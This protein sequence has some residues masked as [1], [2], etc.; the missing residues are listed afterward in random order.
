MKNNPDLNELREYNKRFMSIVFPDEGADP[1]NPSGPLCRDAGCQMTAMRYQTVDNFLEMN[2][3]LF[4]RAGY[5]FSLKPEALRYKIV[6]IP[7]PIPQ[8]PELSYETRNVSTD[9]YSFDT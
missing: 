6:T 8:D 4:D 2:K 9:F 5:A 3:I 7:D 1:P